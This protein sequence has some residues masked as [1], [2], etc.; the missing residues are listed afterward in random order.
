MMIMAKTSDAFA[1]RD[2]ELN[3]IFQR[4]FFDQQH[5]PNNTDEEILKSLDVATLNNSESMV[6]RLDNLHA[7]KRRVA[8]YT[9]R[10][11]NHHKKLE[12]FFKDADTKEKFDRAWLLS[13]CYALVVE[14]LGNL[15][16]KLNRINLTSEKSI[17]EQRKKEFS[18]RLKKARRAAGLTQLDVALT[19]NSSANKYASYE[20]NKT[21]PSIATLIRI[22]KQL[23]TSAD[24]LLGLT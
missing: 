20:Q 14:L 12:K 6:S 22:C 17:D 10:M 23:N 18:S 8:T 5:L 16:S 3:R 15:Q 11:L 19:L 21:E 24:K 9:K 7:L 1:L 13:Q 2:W 4:K